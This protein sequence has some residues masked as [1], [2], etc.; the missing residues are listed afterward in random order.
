[1]IDKIW[2]HKNMKESFIGALKGL[3]IVIKTERNAKT[4]FVIGIVTIVA[5]LCF[6]LSN[7]ELSLLILVIVAVFVCEVFN[8]LV[9]NILDIIHPDPSPKIKILKDIASSAVLLACIGAAGIGMIIFLPKII[10]VGT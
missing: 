9:E 3:A 1:M 5:G 2:Q 10:G 4:I 7:A 6:N 8:T